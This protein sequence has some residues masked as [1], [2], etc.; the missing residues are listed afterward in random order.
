MPTRPDCPDLDAALTSP[1][2]FDDPYPVYRALQAT[3][4]VHWSNA[5]QV[6]VLTRYDDTVAVL[7]DPATFAS[8]GRFSAYLDKLPDSVQDATGPLRTHYASGLIQSDPPDHTRLRGLLHKVFTPRAV[9]DFQPRVAQ[10]ADELLAAAATHDQVDVV[11]GIGHHL[12]LGVICGI[13]GVPAGDEDRIHEWNRGI[14]GLQASGG[15]RE[16]NTRRAAVAMVEIE[17]YFG[18]LIDER[19]QHPRDDLMTA[20]VQAQDAGDKLNRDELISACVTL[21]LAGHE[22]TRNLIANGTQLLLRRPD[23]CEQLRDQ[24]AAFRGA[25]EEILRM[26]SPIQRGWRRV[27]EPTTIRGVELTPGE[28]VYYMFGAV[29]RDPEMFEDPDTFRMSRSPNR[30]LAFGH[31]IHFCL[32]ASLARM[33]GGILLAALIREYP[34]ARLVDDQVQWQHNYHVRCPEFLSVSL[35]ARRPVLTGAAH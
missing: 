3:Q 4:P 15:V 30:H 5:W 29:N 24:P 31:G 7:S 14:G 27:A 1:S 8:A 19:R 34:E 35:G 2:F 6:W 18:R 10:L 28:L 25:V 11:R 13:L 9:A 12:P 20:L 23:L 32:G 21:L 26:E 16:E 17:E 22:T 33:E